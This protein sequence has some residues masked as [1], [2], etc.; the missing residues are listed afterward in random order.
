MPCPYAEKRGAVVFCKAINKIVNPFVMPCLSNRYTRCKYYR[1]AEERKAAEAVVE[2]REE[3][4]A[5]TA[6]ERREAEPAVAEATPAAKEEVEARPP[7]PTAEAE[8]A[9]TAPA[10]EETKPSEIVWR[11]DESEKLTDPTFIASIVLRAPIYLQRSFNVSNLSDLEHELSV[12]IREWYE[13]CFIIDARPR[14]DRFYLKYCKGR[15]VA[16]ARPGEVV[17]PSEVRDAIKGEVRV[18]VYGPLKED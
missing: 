2:G 18:I 3:V 5:A 7:T 15:L 13:G 11:R 8:A 17:E 6:V 12:A 16:S 10:A 9:T 4:T 14:G 1:A